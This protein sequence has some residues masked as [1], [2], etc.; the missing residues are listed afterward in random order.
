[1][2]RPRSAG[3]QQ[4]YVAPTKPPDREHQRRYSNNVHHLEDPHCSRRQVNVKGYS[5]DKKSEAKVGRRKLRSTTSSEYLE[6]P[7]S[8]D[9]RED[10]GEPPTHDD[11]PDIARSCSAPVW[12]AARSTR[13]FVE[14]GQTKTRDRLHIRKHEARHS[15]P[16][17]V[18]PSLAGASEPQTVVIEYVNGNEVGSRGQTQSTHER[19]RVLD[20]R[21][22]ERR[23]G[24]K[25][26]PADRSLKRQGNVKKKFRKEEE[27][28]C[29]G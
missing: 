11:T 29:R 18:A 3:G 9:Y 14:G 25:W 1:M 2:Q 28:V 22:S 12:N 15:Y 4:H 24:T 17:I 20:E 23:D 7:D 26:F 16:M 5:K 8:E 10:L 13:Q 19:H 21:K 6:S 27:S